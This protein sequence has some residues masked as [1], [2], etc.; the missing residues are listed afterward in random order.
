MTNA[1]LIIDGYL[2]SQVRCTKYLYAPTRIYVATKARWTRDRDCNAS[3]W[4]GPQAE[5]GV[6]RHTT[7]LIRANMSWK[8]CLEFDLTPNSDDQSTWR[9]GK[10]CSPLDELPRWGTMPYSLVLNGVVYIRGLESRDHYECIMHLGYP[11][12]ELSRTLLRHSSFC[13]SSYVTAASKVAQH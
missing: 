4:A 1:K 3:K 9:A 11:R 2:T 8:P 13:H 6:I 5:S 7:T 12:A 10:S